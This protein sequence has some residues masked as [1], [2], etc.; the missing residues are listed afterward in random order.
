MKRTLFLTAY[1]ACLLVITGCGEDPGYDKFAPSPSG[2]IRYVNAVTDAPS[3]VVEF[4]TQSIG[5]TPF[6]QFSS[7]NSV[8][9]G[10]ERN[11][12][13]S[14]VKDNQLEVIATLSISVP[15]DQLKTL[16]LTGTMANLSVVEVLEDLSAPTE[17]D[18]TTT[19]RIANAAGALND[20]VSLTIFDSTASET[21]ISE[22]VIEPGAIS[23][24]LTVE[25]TSSLSIQ[26]TNAGGDILWTSND[27]L[28]ATGVRP[29]IILVDTFGPSTSQSPLQGLYATVG[30][31]FDFPNETF[32]ASVR[33]L[34]AVPDQT[35]IDLYQRSAQSS[36][37]GI[38]S[39]EADVAASSGSYT[40]SV[41]QLAIPETYQTSS[42]FDATTTVI[43]TGT[44]IMTN[45]LTTTNVVID[46]DN[47]S[48]DGITTAINTADNG[49]ATARVITDADGQIYLQIAT[50]DYQESNQLSI[51]VDDDDENDSDASGLSQ[52]A[53]NQLNVITEAVSAQVTVNGTTFERSTNA[54][55]DVINDVTLFILGISPVDTEVEVEITQQSLVAE[56]LFYS[57]VSPY[58]TTATGSVIFTATI[59]N[60]PSTVL[61]SDR[62]SLEKNQHHMLAIS[63][64]GDNVSARITAEEYRPVATESRLSILHAAPSA[65]V[66]DVYVLKSDVTLEGG[67]P[68][69]NNIVPLVTGQF[70]LAPESY[71]LTIT[72][73][74][75][76]TVL[77][78]PEN[79]NATANGFF[80]YVV[81]DADGGGAPLQLIQ[82][83]N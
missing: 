72:E 22:L 40:V 41:Q 42:G 18:T 17:T 81:L 44:L 77:A 48:V 10:L 26:A 14:Y 8:I 59:A 64:T 55:K 30:G 4:G 31:T 1:L 15:Q 43:G 13:I 60:D 78:G 74:E 47:S 66:L 69:G 20:A 37:P 51:V 27:F 36:T 63:G 58:F 61:F 11:T 83:D 39:I 21:P 71:N 34:N 49:D 68:A 79:I 65:S 12:Q 35:A 53:T 38:V 57:D 3:L 19:L 50:L 54:I 82:L 56:D 25:S 5:N 75:S 16:I 7:I 33:I 62:F 70:G 23:D 28:A 73:A 52:L 76:K 9:P 45:G 24:T 80:R 46:E 32:T 67:N 2:S 6:G 29:I